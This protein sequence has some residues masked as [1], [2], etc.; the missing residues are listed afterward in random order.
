[1]KKKELLIIFILAVL[2][3]G[4]SWFWSRY[5]DLG[6]WGRVFVKG[7]PLPYWFDNYHYTSRKP[8][9]AIQFSHVILF[10]DFLFW[11]LVL[12]S[13]RWIFKNKN[14][15]KAQWFK[16][17]VKIIRFLVICFVLAMSWFVLSNIHLKEQEISLQSTKADFFQWAK[18][19]R[20]DQE[21]VIQRYQSVCMKDDVACFNKHR[22]PPDFEL[23]QTRPGCSGYLLPAPDVCRCIKNKCEEVRDNKGDF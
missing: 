5:L 22:Q 3:T 20:N 23:D 17:K 2:I 4:A 18:Y 14:R 11:F 10:I 21:C 13:G 8:L 19:C 9:Y 12:V 16:S 1:M 7:W 15:L 6:F